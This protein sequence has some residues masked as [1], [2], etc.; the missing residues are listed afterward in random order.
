MDGSDVVVGIMYPA[1]W[2]VPATLSAG[3][4]G[5]RALDPRV[6][7]VDCRYAEPSDL[8]AARGAGPPDDGLRARAPRLTAAQ[9]DAFA[10]VEVV[11]AA[12]LPFDVAALAPRLRWV[13][14]IGAGV[15]QLVSAGLPTDRIRLTTAAGVNGAAVAEFAVA[16]L[17]YAWKRFRELDEAQ[18]A[19]RWDGL[20]GR[21][22]TGAT[23]AVVGLGAIG[24]RVTRLLA[25]FGMRVIGVRRDAAAPRP[26][27][28]AAVVPPDGL[29][30]VLGECDAVIAA[31]PET[32]RTVDVMDARAFAAMKP[33]GF[34]CNVGRGSFVVEDALVAALRSGQLAAAALD[35]T[36]VEPLPP[37]SPLWTAPNL[38]ISPHSAS[39]ATSHFAR[40]YRLMRDNLACYLDG[41]PLRNEVRPER[42]Y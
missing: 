33:G 17:L 36:R 42:G 14:G 20:Y 1:E 5:L 18:A 23:V 37:D 6:R 32:A 9:R 8:R 2:D 34:F 27:H 7:V 24:L 19:R 22:L 15:G 28:L 40:V 26:D 31:A 29:L 10:A 4:A 11:L 38:A 39:S 16:R 30:D 21:E 25:A 3:I 12:D 35:V 13:Q 41:R